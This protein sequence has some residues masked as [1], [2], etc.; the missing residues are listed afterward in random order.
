MPYRDMQKKAEWET[1]RRLTRKKELK[2]NKLAYYTNLTESEEKKR[3]ELLRKLR[4]TTPFHPI[5]EKFLHPSLYRKLYGDKVVK[6][7]RY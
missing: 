1:R 4:E 7:D 5:D 2:E 6:K 3:K